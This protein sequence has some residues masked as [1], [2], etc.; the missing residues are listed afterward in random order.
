M[1]FTLQSIVQLTAQSRE[2]P[3]GTID[4]EPKDAL[5]NLH[6]DAREGTFEVAPKCVLN[7]ALELYLQLHLLMESSMH[8]SVQSDSSNAALEGALDSEPNAGLE[9]APESS[10]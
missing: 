3:E 6:K 8:K 5:S 9:E 2:T 10:I 1:H 7:V 4:G